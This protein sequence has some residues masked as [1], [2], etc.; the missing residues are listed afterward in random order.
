MMKLDPKKIGGIIACFIVGGMAFKEAFEDQKR[1]EEFED[2][3]SRV[4]RLEE[5]NESEEESE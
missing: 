4:A 5:D 1:D 2:L 3:K